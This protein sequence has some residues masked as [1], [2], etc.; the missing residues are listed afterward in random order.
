MQKKVENTI[1]IV[2]L[3]IFLAYFL[4]TY[5]LSQAVNDIIHIRISYLPYIILA[6]VMF[7]AF[8]FLPWELALREIKV[9]V[10]ILRSFLMMYAFFGIGASTV[11]IGQLIPLRGLDK[12]KKNARFFSLGVMFFVGATGGLGAV[13]LALISS[14]LLSKFILYLL[15]IFAAAYIFFTVLG[16][17]GPYKKLNSALKYYKRLKNSKTVK[18]ILKYIDGM[19]K[20][21]SLMSQRYFL[22]GTVFFIP[23]LLS[24][25]LL[26]VFV[27]ASF[28]V[29][30]PLIVGVFIFTI[31]VTLG[32]ISLLPSGIGVEDVSLIALML[33]FNIPGVIAVASLIIF[34]FL[35]TFIV[36]IAGYLSMGALKTLK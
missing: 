36:I 4:L 13:I 2:I 15:F 27:L 23:S 18:N 16:F 29:T 12:F 28:N 24:E 17:D 32:N 6:W 34:R 22:L 9:K 7:T 19:R 20:N 31:S 1:I 33:V 25:A 11:G 14:V 30:I 8:K 3:A 10:P 21:R 5:N 35:N 26:L